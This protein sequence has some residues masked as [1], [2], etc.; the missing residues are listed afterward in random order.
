MPLTT[1]L[2]HDLWRKPL[3]VCGLCLHRI[4][5]LDHSAKI[6]HPPDVGPPL[7]VGTDGSSRPIVS[8]IRNANASRGTNGANPVTSPIRRN[9]YRTVFGWTN[10]PRAVLSSTPPAA[11]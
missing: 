2:N 8:A 5:R 3:K 4:R 6:H 7:G 11:K 10:S 1:K 9:R